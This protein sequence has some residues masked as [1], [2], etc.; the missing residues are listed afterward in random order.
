MYRPEESALIV[1]PAAAGG[2]VGTR[3]AELEAVLRTHLWE[4]CVSRR[5][6]GSAMR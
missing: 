4:T 5:P 2:K 6:P 1:N 3:W